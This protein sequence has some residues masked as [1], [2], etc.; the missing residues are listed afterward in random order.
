MEKDLNGKLEVSDL[1]TNE[2]VEGS[3]EI[4]KE[5]NLKFIPDSSFL[6]QVLFIKYPLLM[7]K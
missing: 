3:I 5:L 7:I 4:T 6:V 2:V 1:V